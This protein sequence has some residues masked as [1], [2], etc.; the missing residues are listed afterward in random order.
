MQRA[1]SLLP[2]LA[3][4]GNAL[5][6]PPPLRFCRLCP[7]SAPAVA[8]TKKVGKKGDTVK[9]SYDIKSEGTTLEYVHKPIKVTAT[10]TVGKSLKFAKPT[11]S[12]IFENTYTF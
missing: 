10:T 5:N 1:K 8:V 2:H 6:P 12:A 11:F 3:H 7:Q 9:L 4:F